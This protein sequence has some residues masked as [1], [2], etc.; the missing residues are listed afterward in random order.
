MWDFC[1]ELV[2]ALH[3][4]WNLN[5][6]VFVYFS[7]SVVVPSL[8]AEINTSRSRELWMVIKR[9]MLGNRAIKLL[10]C[11][12]IESVETWWKIL[13]EI[14]YDVYAYNIGLEHVLYILHWEYIQHYT[15]FVEISMTCHIQAHLYARF[16]G[17]TDNM[18]GP[19]PMHIKYVS[20]VYD[21]LW[22][23]NNFPGPIEYV[24]CKFTCSSNNML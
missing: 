22:A 19:S 11:I 8:G 15:I 14:R 5:G 21:R 9:R 12:K 17:M 6:K 4:I 16:L 23:W 20:H 2:F 1:T 18:L 3:V 13:L 24:I 10:I 7:V